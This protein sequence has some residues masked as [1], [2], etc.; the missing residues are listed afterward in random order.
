MLQSVSG[1]GKSI[2]FAYSGDLLTSFT[3]ARSETTTYAYDTSVSFYGGLLTVKTM[4]EGN[5]PY[6]Q[7]YDASGRVA[8]QTDAYNNTF[9]FAYDAGS[10]TMT[11]PD[12]QT[13]RYDHDEQGRLTQYVDE[14]GNAGAIY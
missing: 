6:T 4:P 14:A 5:V 2:T 13:Y 10:T 12:G 3:D 7:T 9:S 11:G 1:G 8:S